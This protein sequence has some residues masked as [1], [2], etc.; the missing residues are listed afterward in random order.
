MGSNMAR[1]LQQK[2]HQLM[3]YDPH[4]DATKE[5]VSN[6]GKY[7]S[8]PAEV[9]KNSERVITMIPTPQDVLQVYLG[10]DGII[11]NSSKDS[12]L[13]DSSTID[14]TTAKKIASEASKHGVRFVDAPVTG[15]VPAARAGTLTFIVGGPKET[16]D[17]I[18]EMLLC[19]GKNV[20]HC[21]D[22]GMGQVAK[23]CNNMLLAISMVGAAE[24][25]NMGQRMGLDPKL[26]TDILNISSGR[27][28]VTEIYNPV[29]G[30]HA[31]APASNNYTGGFKNKLIAKDLN[32][33]QS[34]SV[35]SC[36]PTP[37]GSMAS[38][39]YRMMVNKDKGE[40]DFSSI[41]KFLEE[42]KLSS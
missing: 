3:V 34:M 42:N 15:A 24:T 28:W 29:P 37:M 21:G 31:N 27:S 16:L 7:F 41:Y 6:G 4:K 33:A 17:Q 25:L 9:A 23:L 39:L 5:I 26:L 1:H 2:G 38:I 10:P 19:M 32:L 18:R 22:H 30:I 40:L 12:I 20:I 36:S 8:S 14:P 11:A 13:I 35:E